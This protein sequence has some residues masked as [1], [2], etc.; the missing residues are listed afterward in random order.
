MV[1]T[2]R[3]WNAQ[4]A[5]VQ[6]LAPAGALP[7]W[8]DGDS[9]S[10]DDEPDCHICRL[11]AEEKGEPLIVVC[12][13]TTMPVHHSC[14]EISLRCSIVSSFAAVAIRYALAPHMSR[15]GACLSKWR[16]GGCNAGI[17]PLPTGAQLVTSSIGSQLHHVQLARATTN[18]PSRS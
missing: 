17:L 1:E 11:T 3:G 12:A 15:C 2:T 10:S 18:I 7:G 8:A 5:G 16:R 4:G 9:S 6:P 13:C 14:R